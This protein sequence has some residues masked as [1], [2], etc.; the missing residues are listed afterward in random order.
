VPF[1]NSSYSVIVRVGNAGSANQTFAC[2]IEEYNLSFNLVRSIG[3]SV[4]VPPGQTGAL[5]YEGMRIL[6]QGNFLSLRCI[7]PPRGAIGTVYWS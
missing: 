7:L 5:S 6:A 1:G 2:A 3:K 4:V